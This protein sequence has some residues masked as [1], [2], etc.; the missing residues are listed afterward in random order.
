MGYI[1]LKTR[2]VKCRKPHQCDWCG[3][4]IHVGELADYRVYIFC[5][6]FTTG[7][8]HPEC[9]DAMNAVEIDDL[10]PEGWIAGDFKRGLTAWA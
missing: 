6:D 4:R 10:P 8:Q 2:R 7:H 9:H 5:G 3:E 1:E